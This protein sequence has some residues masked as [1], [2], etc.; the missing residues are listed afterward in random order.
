MSYVICDIMVLN[1]ALY[2]AAA[3]PDAAIQR[4]SDVEA[5]N[6]KGFYIKM[7]GCPIGTSFVM[8]MTTIALNLHLLCPR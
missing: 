3:V 8:D 7:Y 4:G 5:S 2:V 1:E 6:V